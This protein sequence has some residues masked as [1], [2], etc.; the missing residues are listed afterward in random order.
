MSRSIA[1]ARAEDA[2]IRIEGALVLAGAMGDVS[3]F[4]RA[5]KQLPSDLLAPSRRG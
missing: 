2:V 1:R 4:G 3:L 5:L